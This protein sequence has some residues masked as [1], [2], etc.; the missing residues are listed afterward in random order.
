MPDRQPTSSAAL[1]L[2]AASLFL[3]SGCAG[4]ATALGVSAP[5][6]ELAEGRSSHV[7]LELPTFSSPRGTAVVTLWTRVQNPNGFGFTLS[8]LRGELS[9]ENRDMADVDLPLGL[10]LSA[11]GDT[12]IP[13]QIR[14]PIPDLDELGSLGDALLTRRSVAYG[15]DGTVGVDAGEFGE[16]TFGPRTWL[17]G[18]ID[19]RIGVPEQQPE[20]RHRR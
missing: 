8:T 13:L 11:R 4:L 14:F 18:E 5:T 9:L 17:S 10:P 1:P 12:V 20:A 19:V 15:L 7:S 2:V 16:P 3:L 6:F